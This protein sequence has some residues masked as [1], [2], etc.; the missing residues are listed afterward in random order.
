LL[1]VTNFLSLL[2][3]CWLGDRKVIQVVPPAGPTVMSGKKTGWLQKNDSSNSS[4]LS[5]PNQSQS[6]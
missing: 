4:I 2:R 6:G 5:A 1:S 3:H